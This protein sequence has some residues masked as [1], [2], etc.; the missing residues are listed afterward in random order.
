MKIAEI[1]DGEEQRLRSLLS[2]QILDTKAESCY[3]DLTLIAS[4]ICE[5]SIALVSLV[6]RERQWFKSA[7]GVDA[8]ETHR[9]IAFCAHAI[10]GLDVFEVSDA[11][12]DERFYDNPLVTN[13]PHIRFY[14][15]MPLINREGNAL[16]TLCVIDSAPKK[17]TDRQRECLLALSRQVVSQLELRLQTMQLQR[18]ND[19]RERTIAIMSHDLKSSFNAVIGFSKRLSTKA[20]VMDTEQIS[21][22]AKMIYDVGQHA[23]TQL[24]DILD[25]S[26]QQIELKNSTKENIVITDLFDELV[27]SLSPTLKEKNLTLNRMGE[28]SLSIVG[29]KLSLSSILQNLLSNA[30]KFSEMGAPIDV[31]FGCSD[32][33][34][35]LQVRDYGIGLEQEKANTLFQSGERI[36]VEGTA[37][38]IGTGVGTFIVQDL[39]EKAN[40]RIDVKSSPGEGF[41]ATVYLPL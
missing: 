28:E 40:G 12:D 26:K 35:Y 24:N 13:D 25:W 33:E 27:V 3:D 1:P 30:I 2:Y 6:D 10:H 22:S 21:Q 17:L 15:G 23:Y 36:S 4:E 14:A 19:L 29:N 7:V 39:L 41:C 31:S 20:E 9:D 18:M 34:V 8:Q 5:T 37:G 32:S 16:G 11:L 38:E